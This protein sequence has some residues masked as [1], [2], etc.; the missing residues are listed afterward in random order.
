MYYVGPTFTMT[1]NS[2]DDKI[3]CENI[4]NKQYI[5]VLK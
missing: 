4:V 1:M 5:N 3:E 2:N